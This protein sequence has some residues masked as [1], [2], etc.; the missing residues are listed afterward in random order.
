MS[1]TYLDNIYALT[2]DKCIHV[3][4]WQMLSLRV[5]STKMKRQ[6]QN[7]RREA[8]NA[9]NGRMKISQQRRLTILRTKRDGFGFDLS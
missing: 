7:L 8:R 5:S 9:G 1:K 2:E 6:S 3:G 4:S